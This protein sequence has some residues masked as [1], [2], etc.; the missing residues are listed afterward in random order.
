V[1]APYE[2]DDKV[3]LRLQPVVA[4]PEDWPARAFLASLGLSGDGRFVYASGAAGLDADG[5]EDPWLASVTVYD[6]ETG[7]IQ[8]VYGSVAADGWV[9]FP[10]LP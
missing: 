9:R 10:P 8:V 1:T 5:R 4:R 3:P 6:A 7:Q 2:E